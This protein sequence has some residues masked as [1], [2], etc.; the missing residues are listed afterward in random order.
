[1]CG[2]AG[3]FEFNTGKAVDERILKVMNRSLSHRGPDDEGI[4][5][6]GNIG[7]GNRRLSII[8][9]GGGHQPIHNEDRSLWIIFNGEIY[10]F[11]KLRADLINKGHQFYTRTDTETILHLYEEMGEECVK[12]LDG[13]FAFAIW[14]EKEGSLFLARDPLGKKPLHWGTFNNKFVFASE[15]KGV[16]AH[17]EFKKEIDRQSLAKYLLYGFV[18]APAT[19]FKGIKKLLPGHFMVVR[20]NGEVRKERYWELNYSEK[21]KV[22][23]KEVKRETKRL[24]K[25]AVKKRLLADVPLGVFLS[26]GIDS[27]LVVAMMTELIPPSQVQAFS[28]GFLEKEVN[29]LP[30]A[31]AV[32]DHLG[33]THHFKNFS[34]KDVLE[35]MPR[36]AD[37]L[38]EPMADPSILPTFLLSSFVKEGV[39]VAL[40]GD[41]GDENFAGYPKYLAH[42]LL[43]KTRLG[44]L[45][46]SSVSGFFPGKFEA[47]LHYASY[48]LHLRNQLWISHFSPTEVEELLGE[49]ASFD[50]P[51]R[52]HQRFNGQNSLDE[53]FF[54]DQ[55]LT[56]PDLY[57]V[58]TDR[59][60]MAASLEVRCPFLDKS[61]IE[62]SATIPA[63]LKLKNFQTKSLLKK[64][65][66][67]RLP[68]NVVNRPKRGFGIPLGKWLSGELG[69]LVKEK[70]DPI[71]IKNEG[72]FNSQAVAGILE[73]GNPTQIWTLLVFELWRE[74]WMKSEK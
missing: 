39:T 51:E 31:R 54:L 46:L 10:N 36:I 15:I 70:L 23:E 37:F 74:K 58:K 4:Y 62:F 60:S 50:D 52:Y 45:P 38:D 49:R 1:M 11:L 56:L 40:S 13:M 30:Y 59:A 73:R 9:V 18:P 55:N 66:L 68:E 44:K 7:L 22:S 35:L 8:D 3:V 64:I 32:A 28:I 20:E 2:I 71:K 17:P 65:A 48:P 24:L 53:A 57:L 72:L 29:E 26:G 21:T 47:F 69:P 34:Q 5:L 27:S 43:E 63:G 14:D 25:E 16:L 33:V 61:L 67:E 41:G 6:E 12:R 42:H 19:I